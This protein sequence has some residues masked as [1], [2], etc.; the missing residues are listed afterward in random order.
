M[1]ITSMK[2]DELKITYSFLE[3]REMKTK[4]GPLWRKEKGILR[5][6]KTT[7]TTNNETENYDDGSSSGSVMFDEDYYDDIAESKISNSKPDTKSVLNT[8]DADV[9]EIYNDIDESEQLIPIESVPSLPIRS[10]GNINNDDK[11]EFYN[12]I[13]EPAEPLQI[14][15]KSLD[16]RPLL[17]PPDSRN[18]EFYNDIEEFDKPAPKSTVKIIEKRPPLPPPAPPEDDPDEIYHDISD[19]QKLPLPKPIIQTVTN[20]NPPPLPARRPLPSIPR[21]DSIEVEET[22]DDV[23]C[24]SPSEQSRVSKIHRHC[25][26]T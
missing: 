12:D 17:P 25:Q 8:P 15:K 3:V 2:S 24:S 21:E 22:Y 6:I 4:C 18:E 11:E 13:E 26:A 10:I 23:G 7:A 19:Y 16:K 14:G 9:E 20:Q 1:S 5:H